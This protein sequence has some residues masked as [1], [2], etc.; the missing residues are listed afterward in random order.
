[1]AARGAVLPV[2]AA[3]VSLPV[4]A[5]A[6]AAEAPRGRSPITQPLLLDEIPEMLAAGG[7]E[8]LPC[9]AWA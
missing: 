2:P 5:A 7:E 4:E 1:V 3:A 6:R 8:G 9:L